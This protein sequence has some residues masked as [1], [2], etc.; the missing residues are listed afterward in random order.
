MVWWLSNITVVGST[1]CHVVITIIVVLS[2]AR[3]HLLSVDLMCIRI[4]T[5]CNNSCAIRASRLVCTRS[6]KT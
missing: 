6:H 3:R 1:T 5:N 4:I 2:G